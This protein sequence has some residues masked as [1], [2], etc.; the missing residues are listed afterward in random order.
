MPDYRRFRM[1]GGTYF[2][3]LNLLNRRLSL[4]TNHHELLRESFALVHEKH[5][6]HLDAIVVLPEH[7]HTLMT[8]P[9]GDDDFST[10]LRMIKSNLSRHLPADESRSSSRRQQNERGIW[11]R[12]FWEHAIRDEIDYQRHFD[13][14]HFNPVKH[15]HARRPVDWPYSSI[16]KYIRAGL[17]TAD[18]GTNGLSFD[19]DLG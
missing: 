16:H 15:G 2:F 1:P 7:L 19:L 8:L 3:T 6:F 14:I 10:R 12:R 17:L 18:W 11:Q 13:Y 9:P 5:P 4:L